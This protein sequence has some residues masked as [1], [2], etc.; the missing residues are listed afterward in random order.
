MA[1]IFL[2]DKTNNIKV[3]CVAGEACIQGLESKVSTFINGYG[4]TETSILCTDGDR[5]DT[6]GRPLPNT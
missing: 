4:P 6:I 3:M 5:S 1:D 2:R